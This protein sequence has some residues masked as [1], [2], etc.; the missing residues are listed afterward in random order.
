MNPLSIVITELDR[1]AKV[2]ALK[3]LGGSC[4]ARAIGSVRQEI[5]AAARK[6][7]NAG[8]NPDEFTKSDKEAASHTADMDQRNHDDCETKGAA[9]VAAKSEGADTAQ[10]ITPIENARTCYSIY[11]WASTEVET[12][13]MSIW[14]RIST[15][16]D[17]VNKM[18][19]QGSRGVADAIVEHIAKELKTTPAMLRAMQEI[20]DKN[21][22]AQLLAQRPEILAYLEGM[23]GY[24]CSNTLDEADP[25]LQ[26]Q[27]AVRMTK[28]LTDEMNRTLGYILRSGKLSDLA[29]ITFIK[30]GIATMTEWV[31]AWEKKHRSALHEAI[32]AG[33]TINTL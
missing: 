23:T 10:P 28:S 4:L 8:A 11:E 33:R 16:N 5:R 24:S 9:E 22:R 2:T 26:H 13:S 14:D 32:D 1:V 7:R 3:S 31:M 27:L 21:D 25:V 29:N 19:T 30:N 15:P 6:E 18:I 12:L 20:N 17:M